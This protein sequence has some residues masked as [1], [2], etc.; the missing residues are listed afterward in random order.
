MPSDTALA[1]LNPELPG[2]VVPATPEPEPTTIGLDASGQLYLYGPTAAAPGPVIPAVMGF[3]AGI[4]LSQH[5]ATSRYGLRDYL[6]LHMVHVPGI[7]YVL[8]LP[9]QFR[10]HEQ[11]GIPMPPCS[12]RSLLAALATL[13]LPDRAVKLQTKR[14]TKG[15]TIF[16]VI[17][18]GDDGSEMPEVQATFKDFGRDDFEIAV[19]RIRTLLGHPPLFT[20]PHDP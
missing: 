18:F 8:R 15:G 16:R 9:A 5:G 12:V 3:V 10:P 13:D 19:N 17:P 2:W 1:P 11:T 14:G 20:S 4:Y 7:E 6:N